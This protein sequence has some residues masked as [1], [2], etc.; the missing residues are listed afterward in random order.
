MEIHDYDQIPSYCLAREQFLQGTPLVD[1][2]F[3]KACELYKQD[4]RKR[5]LKKIPEIIKTGKIQT[6][7]HC[8]NKCYEVDGSVYEMCHF[9]AFELQ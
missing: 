3:K 2:Q 9:Q 6:I 5:V 7:D 1:I 4:L 8:F